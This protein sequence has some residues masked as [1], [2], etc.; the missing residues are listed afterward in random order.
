[1]REKELQL[2]R[3]VDRQLSRQQIQ[4]LIS[5]AQRE[6]ELWQ[7]IAVAFVE[8][9][10]F[11]QEINA[12]EWD[13]PVREKTQSARLTQSPPAK[14]K[15]MLALAAMLLAGLWLGRSLQ[16][17][18]TTNDPIPVVKKNQMNGADQNQLAG[19]PDTFDQADLDSVPL[20]TLGE[21]REKGLLTSNPVPQQM[22][23][24]L[25]R[26]GIQL[27]QDTQF[28]SGR[29]KD[30]RRVLFPVQSISFNPGN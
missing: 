19:S 15:I 21:A 10:L 9:Q 23:D 27:E 24:H 30:G 1:M 18:T 25:N 13:E 29:T 22:V 12:I 16:T 6:P 26:N 11:D 3:L 28:V 20:Y 2:Q 8:E 17:Q 5:N 4:T 7:D 14:A